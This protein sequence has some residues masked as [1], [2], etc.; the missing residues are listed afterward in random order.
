[1]DSS[2]FKRRWT[3]FRVMPSSPEISR[4]QRPASFMRLLSFPHIPHLLLIAQLWE[5]PV[6]GYSPVGIIVAFPV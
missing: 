3:V 2:G 4:T 5:N 6:T 1:M